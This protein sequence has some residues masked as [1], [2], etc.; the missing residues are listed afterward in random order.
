[1]TI[2]DICAENDARFY[3]Q[4]Y[5]TLVYRIFYNNTPSQH[6]LHFYIRGLNTKEYE[7]INP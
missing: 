6:F 5:Y 7:Q 3:G 4:R 2:H 1:M